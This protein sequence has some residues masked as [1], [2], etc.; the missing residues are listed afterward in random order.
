MSQSL[1]E[2]M[3]QE[4]IFTL[5]YNDIEFIVEMPSV[6]YI[7]TGLQK[8]EQLNSIDEARRFVKGWKNAT[9]DK[10]VTDGDPNVEVEYSPEL[11]DLYISDNIQLGA[12]V[13]QETTQKLI[14][15]Q[16]R[17]A[18]LGKPLPL[19]SQTKKSQKSTTKK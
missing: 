7:L 2:R 6:E 18:D 11:F 8:E 13:V 5:T 9:E 4:R 10:F 12:L 17:F 14:E 16:N 19:S 15:K 1:I 3:K